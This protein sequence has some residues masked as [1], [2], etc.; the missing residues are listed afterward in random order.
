MFYFWL[1][2]KRNGGE[3]GLGNYNVTVKWWQWRYET[4]L[5]IQG[6]KSFL[7]FPFPPSLLFKIPPPK[8]FTLIKVSFCFLPFH[9]LP[10]LTVR[11]LHC[12]ALHC[13][14][15]SRTHAYSKTQPFFLH[16]QGKGNLRDFRTLLSLWFKQTHLITFR[17]CPS[18]LYNYLLLFALLPP[19]PIH[20]IHPNITPSLHSFPLQFQTPFFFTSCC[21]TLS[22]EV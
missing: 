13:T 11:N 20:Q 7:S 21:S 8:D 6:E 4:A 18:L 1:K 3:E 22:F 5:S 15:F 10:S 14:L 19:L 2:R 9:F 12:T 16:T 17:S